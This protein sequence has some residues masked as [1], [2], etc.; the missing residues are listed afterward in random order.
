MGVSEFTITIV[1]LGLPGIICYFVLSRLVGRDSRNALE[2]FL[3][4]FVYAV[5]SYSLSGFVEACVNY[6]YGNG[7]TASVS[8]LLFGERKQVSWEQLISAVGSA[9][10]LAYLLSYGHRYNI[11]NRLGQRIGAT[12]HYGDEDVW[13]FFHNAPDEEKNG[14]WVT[15]RDHKY[16]LVYNGHI[17]TWSDS[18]KDRELVISEVSVYPNNSEEM[19]YEA[20]QIYLSRK[21][22]ELTIEVRPRLPVSAGATQNTSGQEEEKQDAR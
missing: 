17:S 6:A 11:L 2:T 9:I 20:D 19:L 10:L 22:D 18:G 15:V 3:L 21:A 14:G 4:I 1:I 13:Q 5:L 12:K 8:N 7:F 16:D